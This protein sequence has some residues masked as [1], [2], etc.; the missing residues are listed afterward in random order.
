MYKQLAN[1][2][3]E[4]SEQGRN[5]CFTIEKTTQIPTY[6]YLIRYWGRKNEA[7]RKCPGC[8]GK[9]FIPSDINEPKFHQFEFMCSKCKLVSHIPSSCDN[10]RYARIGEYK[11]RNKLAGILNRL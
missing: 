10:E 4:L 3:S 5:I 2:N 9:W 6:Y 11:K 7:D 8:G 1:P